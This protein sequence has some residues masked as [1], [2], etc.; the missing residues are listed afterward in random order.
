MVAS[1][2]DVQKAFEDFLRVGKRMIGTPS[3]LAALYLEI[4]LLTIADSGG[5]PRANSQRASVTYARCREYLEQH[6]MEVRTLKDAARACHVDVT[7]FCRLFARF[8]QRSPYD[9]LQRLRMNHAA[10]MLESGRL[11]VREVA[12]ALDMDA[13]HFSRAFKRIYGL[14]P[15]AFSS[16]RV[17]FSVPSEQ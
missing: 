6:F 9:F 5:A 11:L 16:E 12:D 7:Y 8:A 14:S 10:T 17:Q 4:L 3:R 15:S 13:F 1:C 2:D